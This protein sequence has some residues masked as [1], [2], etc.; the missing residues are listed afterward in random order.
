MSDPVGP[1]GSADRPY[2]ENPPE[3]LKEVHWGGLAVHFGAGAGPDVEP[4]P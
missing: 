1:E 3:H 2:R 4:P